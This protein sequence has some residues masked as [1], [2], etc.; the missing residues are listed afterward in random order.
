MPFD[1]FL[2]PC[3]STSMLLF[4]FSSASPS[5]HDLTLSLSFRIWSFF[6][7]LFFLRFPALTLNVSACLL[8]VFLYPG[9]L[10]RMGAMMCIYELLEMNNHVL[11]LLAE[12]VLSLFFSRKGR[13]RCF[14]RFEFRECQLCLCLCLCLS[15]DVFLS[16]PL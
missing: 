6:S 15:I 16:P 2:L 3:A 7:A 11:A 10:L 1:F 9:I 13:I 8:F 12:L 4:S 5:Y 14:F